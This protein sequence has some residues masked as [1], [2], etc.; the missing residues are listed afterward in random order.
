MSLSLRRLVIVNADD[1]GQTVGINA[2]VRRAHE[3]G[4]LTSASL[5]V[6]WAAAAD[7]ADYARTRP[8]LSV[9][10]HVDLGEWEYE[11][12]VWTTRY[13]VI[14]I[15]DE[16]AVREEVERQVNAFRRL[17]HRDPTHLDS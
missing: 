1:F 16:G 2:G 4:I 17:A 3:R 9:G 5:M 8:D 10:L 11:A 6:R 14:P 7:A 12:G 15:D 13:D